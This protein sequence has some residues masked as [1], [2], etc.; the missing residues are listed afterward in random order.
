MI[1]NTSLVCQSNFVAVIASYLHVFDI[2]Q[3]KKTPAATC[4][5]LFLTIK[6]RLR[7]VTCKPQSLG[8]FASRKVGLGDKNQL[9][10][11]RE[12]RNPR[13]EDNATVFCML[14]AKMSQGFYFY[15]NQMQVTVNSTYFNFLCKKKF[16]DRLC[17]I[18]LQVCK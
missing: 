14:S 15:H 2:H 7:E 6:Q 3:I 5:K 1:Y 16:E 11:K 4:V 18:W 13:P 9:F 10:K 17:I 12:E 8:S